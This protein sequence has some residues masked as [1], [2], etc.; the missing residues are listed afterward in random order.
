MPISGFKRFSIKLLST[1]FYVGYFPLAPGTFASLVSLF[2]Y[3]LI[4]NNIAAQVSVLLFLIVLGLFICGKAEEVFNKKDAPI[5]VIDEVAGMLLTL[6]FIGYSFKIIL[7]GFFLFRLFDTLKVFPASRLERLG[8]AV[9]IMGDDIIAGL[10]ANAL[11]HLLL[12]VAPSIA[13]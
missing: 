6:I 3:L 5:I 12:R 13:S 11:L 8:G 7:I 4:N 10:Y 1:F 9:G 2:I